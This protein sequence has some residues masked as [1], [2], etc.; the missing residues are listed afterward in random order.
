[1]AVIFR[2][3]SETPDLGPCQA[4]VAVRAPCADIAIAGA[5]AFT[6]CGA[7]TPGPSTESGAVRRYTGRGGYRSVFGGALGA[8]GN[9]MLGAL[10]A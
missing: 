8:A 3:A 7:G 1:V 5:A 4:D 2:F 9:T 6:S 10:D